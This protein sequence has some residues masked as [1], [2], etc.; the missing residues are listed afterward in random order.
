MPS[1]RRVSPGRNWWG[2]LKPRKADRSPNQAKGVCSQSSTP[3]SS[4]HRRMR[5]VVSRS[6]TPGRR[7]AAT[8]SAQR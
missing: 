8:S 7:P 2:N 5:L 4:S 1:S 3:F 6:V